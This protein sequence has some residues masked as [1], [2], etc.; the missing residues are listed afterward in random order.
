M[1][2]LSCASGPK[3]AETPAVQAVTAVVVANHCDTLSKNDQK[4]AERV[5]NHLVERCTHV[6]HGIRTFGVVLLPGGGIEFTGDADAGETE[7]P[8]CVVS[9]LLTH[10]VKLGTKCEIDVRLEESQV[11]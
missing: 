3:E 10:N 4:Q 6:P 8:I 11:H 9:H 7:V 5:M 2:L 1:C